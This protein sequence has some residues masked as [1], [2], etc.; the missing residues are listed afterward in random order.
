MLRVGQRS[1][2]CIAFLHFILQCKLNIELFIN[3]IHELAEAVEEQVVFDFHVN[4][5]VVF[6]RH[7]AK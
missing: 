6:L 2:S 7:E 3:F 1:Y 5:K 4:I